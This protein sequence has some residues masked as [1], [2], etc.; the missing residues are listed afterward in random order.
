M[1]V[2]KETKHKKPSFK[3]TKNMSTLERIEYYITEEGMSQQDA[4]A[5]AYDEK[6]QIEKDSKTDEDS[7]YA[8]LFKESVDNSVENVKNSVCSELSKI[9]VTKPNYLVT[10]T[11][12]S[13]VHRITISTADNRY[14]NSFQFVIPERAEVIKRL[15]KLFVDETKELLHI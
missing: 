3:S 1:L 14:V 2:I 13:G 5:K 11:E 15:I 9:G 6:G 4:V 12:Q 8:D 7:K 10:Y